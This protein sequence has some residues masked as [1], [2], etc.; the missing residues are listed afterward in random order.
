MTLTTV[1][2]SVLNRGVN[3]KDFGAVGDGVTDDTAAI[4][5]AVDAV[6]AAGGGALHF[7]ANEDYYIGSSITI[8]GD[9][10]TII[11]HG[12]RI[13]CNATMGPEVQNKPDG[14]FNLIGTE[15][16]NTTLAS[17]A[18]I[19][20]ETVSV[21]SATGFSV[22]Q[23]IYFYNGSGG[24]GSL[25]YT[26]GG[27]DVYRSHITRITNISGTT[28]TLANPLPFALD[29]TTYTCVVRVWDGVKRFSIQGGDWDGGGY[30]HD[31]T[32]GKGNALLYAQYAQNV[33]VNVS[34][35]AGFSGASVWLEKTYGAIVRGGTY[36]GHR[37]NYTTALVED[38]N[39]GFY[40]VRM[41]ECR[42]CI[43]D[44]I[45]GRRLRHITDGARTEQVVI[46]NITGTNS[47]RTPFGSHSGCTRW[48]H[49]NLVYEGPNG[50]FLWRGFDCEV[51]N[52]SIICPH[53]AEPAFYD[54]VGAAADLYRKYK[55]S[56]LST[57]MAREAIRLEA[58][59]DSCV[60]DGGHLIGAQEAHLIQLYLSTPPD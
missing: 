5:A 3:V 54:T 21:T 35:A 28:I 46:S 34:R 39:S 16:A 25:W 12:A 8:N 13:T 38:Q 55:I 41:D 9:D 29:A 59:I 1:K 36:E 50:G 10:I 31:L 56:G 58:N 14:I 11:A 60:V 57:N 53:D 7:G 2:G 26:E 40:G 43:V 19:Q 44:G 48:V 24:S 52:T 17:D 30:D 37:D 33:S 47:H 32:N 15:A 23:V 42:D 27:T 4:Q 20:A 18:A 45:V 22:G 6:E 51:H 49:S